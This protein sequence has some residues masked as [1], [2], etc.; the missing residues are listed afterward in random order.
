MRER[1]SREDWRD[2]GGDGI[3]DGAADP[4]PGQSSADAAK[5]PDACDMGDCCG[6]MFAEEEVWVGESGGSVWLLSCDMD[7]ECESLEGRLLPRGVL[8]VAVSDGVRG[9][10]TLRFRRCRLSVLPTT[11][12]RDAA[13]TVP[14]ASV[15]KTR[16]NTM[17]CSAVGT[18]THH[19]VPSRSSSEHSL[20]TC[21]CGSAIES[22]L[23]YSTRQ[24]SADCSKQ[25]E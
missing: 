18:D 1:G 17:S 4:L 6:L 13:V 9:V 15:A 23:E 24:P 20:A 12:G 8:G 10:D 5:T 21:S 19:T 7:A 2:I 16:R 14:A 22:A 25:A 11:M 3:G